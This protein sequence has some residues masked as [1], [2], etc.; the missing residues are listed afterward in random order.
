MNYKKIIPFIPIVG[1]IIVL[2]KENNYYLEN[3]YIFYQSVIIQSLSFICLY[4]LF[5]RYIIKIIL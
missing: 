3:N 1:F 4:V 5:V 2:I